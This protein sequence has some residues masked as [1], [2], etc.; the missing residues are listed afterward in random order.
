MHA[1]VILTQDQGP[2][3]KNLT[4]ARELRATVCPT[5]EFTNVVVLRGTFGWRAPMVYTDPEAVVVSWR[6]TD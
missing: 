6:K 3:V 2:V 5:L 1:E 4:L